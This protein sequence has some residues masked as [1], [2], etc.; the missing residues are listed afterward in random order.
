MAAPAQ[1]SSRI[2][3]EHRNLALLVAGCAFI[4]LLDG[5]IV[6]TSAPKIARALHV[7]V[8]SIGLLIT[9]YLVTVAVLIPLSG[10][11]AA[12]LGGR[13]TLL[14]AISVFVL[15]SIGC[16]VSTSLTELVLMRVLQGAGGAMM[17]PVGRMLV[18]SRA[19]SSNLMRVTALLIW[20]GL[21]A[22][23]LAPLL[24]G[25][26]TTYANW[27][28]LFLIN[29]PLGALGLATAARIVHPPPLPD[30]GRLDR[31]G[32][33]L[34]GAGLGG[35]TVT[36]DL[37]AAGHAKWAPIAGLGVAS[38]VLLGAAARHLL[39]ADAPLVDLRLA[40]RVATL[41]SSL[42]G[43]SLYFTVMSSG[44]F[45]APLM[46]EE[47]FHWSAIKAGS[48]VVFLF[49]GNIAIK[50]A[51]TPLYSR[52]G[53]RRV[54]IAATST[55]AVAMV[56]LGL[57]TA[58]VPLPVLALILVVIGASRSMG[59]T[60]YTTLAYTDVPQAE[61]RHA[62]TLQT[63]IQMLGAGAG[64]AV[65]AIALRIGHPLGKLLSP[66]GGAHAE[67]VVAFVV[68]ACL[69]LLAT[70]EASRMPAGAGDALRTRRPP[71]GEA[72]AARA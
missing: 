48:L 60:G 4:E 1:T 21:V 39:G 35:L 29:V 70:L 63:T 34:L 42:I 69:S 57:M 16:A 61:M 71:P 15:G 59:A 3:P 45:L 6:T 10:W 23:V 66:A 26:I 2:E 22:P 54:L 49:V 56:I 41:R 18:V 65:S 37:I 32:V 9:A 36:A 14:S 19:D 33:L 58:S 8:G 62:S 11:T 43:S 50:P 17:V 53:F 28:W 68:M 44:P 52:Y 20:P 5:T 67:Y 13:A 24:G 47:V 51:T 12:R 64:V 55:M 40:R 30:P 38:A 25:L 46:F 27:H 7:S 31:A 72:P